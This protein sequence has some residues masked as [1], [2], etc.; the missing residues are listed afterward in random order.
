M[1]RAAK[2]VWAALVALA[3][4][5][6]AWSQEMARMDSAGAPGLAWIRQ[7]DKA[8]VAGLR[9]TLADVSEID[10]LDAVTVARLRAIDLGAIPG[11]G[12]QL[13]LSR[14]TLREAV[15]TAKLGHDVTWDGARATQVDL[16]L[17]TL[18]GDEIAALG[19]R[20]VAKALGAAGSQATFAPSAAPSGLACV[21]GRWSTRVSVRNALGER[22]SGAVRLEAVAV[23]DG[24]ERSVVSFVLEVERKGR[25]LVAARDLTPGAAIKAEDLTAVERNLAAVGPDSVEHPERVVGLVLARRVPAGQ[26]ITTRDV[27]LP[28]VIERDDVVQVRYRA[29]GLKV[30][31]LGRAQASG[32]PGERIPVANLGSGKVLHAIVVD[33]R[34]VE[35]STGSTP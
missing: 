33:S 6:G 21:A 34:T 10:A 31:G 23:A 5:A 18:S 16:K 22:F 8:E 32:A 15:A 35:V 28:S 27:R 4:A 1:T 24:V 13:V 25:V 26:A 11:K 9:L 20:H 3:F 14:E 29:G 7:R 17:F 12:R 2:T 30:T 19:R